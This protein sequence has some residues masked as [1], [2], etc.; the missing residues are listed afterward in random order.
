MKLSYCKGKHS[1]SALSVDFK[2]FIE[3]FG[4]GFFLAEFYDAFW[5]TFHIGF[6]AFIKKTFD[7][8]TH[9]LKFGGKIE[10]TH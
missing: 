9:P 1:V 6:E 5:R 7:Q 2:D 8:D 4:E 3:I 10:S